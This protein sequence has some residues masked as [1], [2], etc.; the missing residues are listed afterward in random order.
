MPGF[1]ARFAAPLRRT[2][3][4]C[5]AAA[6]AQD[7]RIQVE[8][9]QAD[10]ND[11]RP[12]AT[13]WGWAAVIAGAWLAGVSTAAAQQPPSDE[14]PTGMYRAL[15]DPLNAPP[16]KAMGLFQSNFLDALDNARPKLQV[17]WVIDATTSMAPDLRALQQSLPALVQD[18]RRAHGN[19]VSFAL[20]VFR[21]EGS[22]FGRVTVATNDFVSDPA[23]FI[24][25]VKAIEIDSGSPYFLEPVDEAVHRGLE[26]PWDASPDTTRWM[27]VATDAPPFDVGMEDP[28]VNAVRRYTND[29][30]INLANQKKVQIHGLLCRSNADE[31]AAFHQVLD[32]TRGFLRAI[33][34]GANGKLLDTSVPEVREE[35]MRRSQAI[36]HPT[37]EIGLI[38]EDDLIQARRSAPQDVRVAVLPHAPLQQMTFDTSEPGA[39]VALELQ[40]KLHR[41]PGL[42]VKPISAVRRAVLDFRRQEEVEKL[43]PQ[44]VNAALAMKLNVDYVIWGRVDNAGGK[45]KADSGVFD[46]A[47][48]DLVARSGAAVDQEDESGSGIVILTS[49]L[50]NSG[51]HKSPR[52]AT[53]G[54]S[55]QRLLDAMNENRRAMSLV[56]AEDR[57]VQQLLLAAYRD[58]ESATA[59]PLGDAGA[60]ALL[61]SA[62]E[63]LDKALESDPSHPWANYLLAN[64]LYNQAHVFRSASQLELMK[65]RIEKVRPTLN[66]AYRHRRRLSA[67]VVSEG[68]EAPLLADS[69]IRQIEADHAL[70]VDRDFTKAMQLYATIAASPAAPDSLRRSAHWMLLGLNLGDWESPA[71]DAAAA[72]SAAVAILAHW[73]ESPEAQFLRRVLRWRAG[74][75]SR[76]AHLPLVNQVVMR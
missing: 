38:D 52:K 41:V 36:R 61:R 10:M 11:K 34:L 55:L 49:T 51:Y 39:F 50:A 25:A 58:L 72:R 44:N 45:L 54:E 29:V 4:D 15:F 75:G 66:Q 12:I 5:R 67:L 2:L 18:L 57:E 62:E 16:A 24:A 27:I 26:L 23:Q 48:G 9:E 40:E 37:V 20:V 33:S 46:G 73:P 71:R 28:K 1:R 6:G 70:I 64:C 42:R 8:V 13:R 30:L 69:V 68:N 31:Y 59:Y 53:S 60:D 43:S 65:E 21:D 76:F 74:E 56:L 35:L 17:A 19:Q 47:H 22:R 32:R 14:R 3:G 63:M 7:G